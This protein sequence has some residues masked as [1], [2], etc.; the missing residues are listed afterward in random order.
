MAPEQNKRKLKNYLLKNNIQIKIVTTNMIYWVLIVLVI[1]A[2]IL[3]P[4]Y[5]NI[6]H[7]NTLCDQYLA[8]KMFLTL[9][10]QTVITLIVIFI[11][12]FLYQ[13]FT[14][15][16]YCGPLVNFSHT[17]NKIASG[18]LTRKVF[19]RRHDLLKQ[20]ANQVNEMIDGL[21]E[22]VSDVKEKN[23]KLFETIDNINV[24]E[25]APD[26]F[27]TVIAEIK[28]QAV[29]C[30]QHLSKFKLTTK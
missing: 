2:T 7:S 26:K 15:H 16:K 1:I 11:L 6:F 27:E 18:D 24:A 3:A 4:F 19:L 28:Q 25:L 29:E 17:F 5:Y 8:A 22:I 30:G 23:H 21:A 13:L 14:T 9:I 12:S 20:E 10:H